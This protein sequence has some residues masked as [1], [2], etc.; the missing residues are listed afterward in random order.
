[1]KV[2]TQQPMERYSGTH[3]KTLDGTGKGL[4]KIGR[5]IGGPKE[6]RDSTDNPTELANLDP[7]PGT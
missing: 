5:S 3:T 1:M 7:V 6:D 2:S 4:E